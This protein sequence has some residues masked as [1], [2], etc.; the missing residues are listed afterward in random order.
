MTTATKI[1]IGTAAHKKATAKLSK[2]LKDAR[3]V[4]NSLEFGTD[5]FELAMNQVRVLTAAINEMTDFGTLTSIEGDVL[6][7]KE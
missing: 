7:V 5:E 4:V 6:S 2:Q 3:A 1:K